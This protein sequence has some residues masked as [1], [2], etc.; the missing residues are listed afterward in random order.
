MKRFIEHIRIIFLSLSVSLLIAHSIVPHDHHNNEQAKCEQQTV[1]PGEHN[2][3]HKGLP[4]HCHA[5]NDLA[6]EKAVNFYI[7]KP[8]QLPEFLPGCIPGSNETIL[9][10]SGILYKEEDIRP[11][12]HG[13]L[14]LCSLRAPP[15]IIA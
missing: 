2:S 9:T 8:E 14:T 6:S 5:F 3:D 13:F 1:P 11:V 15:A 12:S 4:V 7:I 10:A